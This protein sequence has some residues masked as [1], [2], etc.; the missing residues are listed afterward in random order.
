MSFQSCQ[1]FLSNQSCQSCQLCHFSPA[2]NRQSSQLFQPCQSCQSY[3]SCSPVSHG[4]PV[5]Q[6]CLYCCTRQSSKL[7]QP[8]QSCKSCEPDTDS[9][10]SSPC[11][12]FK[13]CQFCQSCASPVSPVGHTCHISHFNPFCRCSPVSPVRHVCHI[14]TI[15]QPVLSPSPLQLQPLQSFCSGGKGGSINS[16]QLA[17]GE[18]YVGEKH[19][20]QRKSPLC[21]PFLGK[22]RPPS[23]PI[24]TFMCL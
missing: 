13:P 12:P 5:C 24:S 18:R 9:H 16:I 4:S 11:K 17:R 21:I 15:Q 7:F 6:S 1:N 19:T 23:A 20:L 3:Q 14:L 2:W 8:S 22:A 10:V